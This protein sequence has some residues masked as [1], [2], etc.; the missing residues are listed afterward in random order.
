[1]MVPDDW[2]PQQS[3]LGRLPS[4][5]KSCNSY[6]DLLIFHRLPCMCLFRAPS[7]SIWGIS[8]SA[9]VYVFQMATCALSVGAPVHPSHAGFCTFINPLRFMLCRSQLLSFWLCVWGLQPGH[10][11]LALSM[12]KFPGCPNPCGRDHRLCVYVLQ[13]RPLVYLLWTLMA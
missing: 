3:L 13:V 10:A 7:N 2:T 11:G 8:S 12:T 6:Q 1:M 5:E 4:R 9:A